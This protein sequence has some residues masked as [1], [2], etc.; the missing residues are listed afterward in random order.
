MEAK[1]INFRR[2]VDKPLNISVD[3]IPTL[4]P[5]EKI[6]PWMD[7]DTDPY[8]KIQEFEYPLEANGFFFGEEFF[9][10]FINKLNTQLIPGSKS[11]HNMDWGRRPS[12]DLLLVGGKLE[13]DGNGKGKA[14]FK[15]YIPKSGDSGDNSVFI[16]ENQTGMV[17][18]SLVA[19]TR[20]EERVNKDT[21][22]LEWWAVESLGSE[23]NDAVG[24]GDGAMEQKTNSRE[25]DKKGEN[26]VTKKELLEALNTMKENNGISLQEIAKAMSVGNLLVSEEQL[27]S[28]STFGEVKKLCGETDPIEFVNSL[29]QEKKANSESVRKAKLDEVFGPEKSKETGKKNHARSFAETMIGESELTDEKVNE[30]KK[31][32]TYLVLAADVADVNSDYNRIEKSNDTAIESDGP[33]QVTA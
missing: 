11:G 22:R 29:I 20:D 31:N 6:N 7:G 8:Y 24:Y 9:E 19:M 21:D 32:E 26:T 3:Q 15:N 30:V 4:A 1:K 17:D 14:Y 12:T 5:D 27:K 28:L 33:V 16:K 23:R 13:K 10:S 25:A 2:I 18:Y